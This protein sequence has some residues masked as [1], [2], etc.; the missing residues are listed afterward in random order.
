MIEMIC[1]CN[2]VCIEYVIAYSILEPL[3]KP[4]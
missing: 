4:R 3:V 1:I 2:S